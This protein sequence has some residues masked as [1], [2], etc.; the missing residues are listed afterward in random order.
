[1]ETE[2]YDD[3]QP[4]RGERQRPEHAEQLVA[5]ENSRVADV[6]IIENGVPRYWRLL[7]MRGAL[8]GARVPGAPQ[9]QGDSAGLFHTVFLSEEAFF[10]Q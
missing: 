8:L 7:T 3:T 4:L 6:E 1:M 9:T 2:C 10:A 5:R